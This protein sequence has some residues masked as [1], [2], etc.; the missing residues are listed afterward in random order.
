[1]L[2]I[3]LDLR[4]QS[5]HYLLIYLKVQKPKEAKDVQDRDNSKKF[6]LFIYNGKRYEKLHAR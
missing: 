6:F 2:E 5:R 1:M 4:D 3:F